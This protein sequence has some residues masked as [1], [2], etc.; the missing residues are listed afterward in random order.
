MDR[1]RCR[2]LKV[3]ENRP[4]GQSE[5]ASRFFELVLE[6]PGW[7]RW[8]PGQFVMV[9]PD[10]GAE[11]TWAR[12]FSICRA[13]ERGLVVFYQVV[14]RGTERLARV[15]PGEE[16]AV[17]GPLGRG[18]A[19]EEDTPTLLLAGGIG[20]APFVGY[21]L[22]HPAPEKLHLVFGHREPLARYPFAAFPAPVAKENWHEQNPGDLQSFLARVREQVAAHAASGLVL[23]CGPLPFLR[24]VQAMARDTGARAQISLENRMACGVGACLGCVTPDADGHRVQVCTHGPVFWSDAVNLD[25]EKPS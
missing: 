11:L 25:P 3:L 8:T 13:D 6:W 14:G 2:T 5:P 18:F 1:Q 16:I 7:S 21:A 17:W 22:A 19:V 23:A 15:A 24:A 12:P 20:V 10:W 4:V 9:R